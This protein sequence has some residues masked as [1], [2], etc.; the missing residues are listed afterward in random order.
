MKKILWRLINFLDN[1]WGY[2]TPLQERF[3]IGE[4]VT[5]SK[6][7]KEDTPFSIREK[8]T[9]VETGRHD[10]L[11]VNAAGKRWTVY[12]FEIDKF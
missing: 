9:I 2:S 8:V 6:H 4:N 5:I 7:K 12:Q 10:Y 3:T 11:V 1:N